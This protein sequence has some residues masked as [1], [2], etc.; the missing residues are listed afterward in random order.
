VTAQPTPSRDAY[1]PLSRTALVFTGSGTAGAYHAGVLR[2]FQ[3][4]GVKIDLVAGTGMGVVSAVFAAID[5]GSRLWEADGIWRSP[6]ARR[7]Y[8][9]RPALRTAAWAFAASLSVVLLPLLVLALGLLVYPLGFLVDLTG[10]TSGGLAS[11]AYTSF[12]QAA[13]DPAFLPSVLP[14]ALLVSLALFVGTL[15]VVL[16][17]V[18]ASGG[19]RRDDAPIWWRVIGAPLSADGAERAVSQ[20]L[21][22]LV[23]GAAGARRPGAVDLSRA[24]TE[25][26]RENLGQPGFREL[27]LTVHDLDMRRDFVFAMLGDRHRR[28]FFRSSDGPGGDR[29][30]SEGFDLAGV[31]RDHL[32]DAVQAGLGLPVATG[33]QMIGFPPESYWCGEVHR[34]ASRPGSVDRLLDELPLAGIEQVIVV[35][36]FPEIE[37]P[38]RLTVPR[39]DWRGRVSDYLAGADAAA[40]RSAVAVFRPFR[41]LHVVR[42]AYNPVG[43][44]DVGG[45]YDQR[46]DRQVSLPELMDRG[47]EDAYRQ[48]IDPV[49]GASGERLATAGRRGWGSAPASEGLPKVPQEEGPAAGELTE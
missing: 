39:S 37:G 34:A 5:G 21:W 29:R 9:M 15:G 31:S 8:R 35:A 32:M 38:H 43:P 33:V 47:Y 22:R 19:K 49:I 44:L 10:A 48:F 7:Y 16:S 3:E 2:A 42:P 18:L 36:P 27:L 4:A 14:R 24:Y 1:S 41:S 45:C 23:G 46:S 40:L 30:L 20:G 28:D 17:R 13:F 11:R 12:V 25:L 26:L 6:A